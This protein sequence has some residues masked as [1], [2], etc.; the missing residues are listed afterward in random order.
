MNTLY[1][2]QLPEEWEHKARIFAALGDGT[3]QKILL[4]FEAGETI[5]L[6]TL[7]E[8]VALSR[9]A[10]V[11][12]VA[13]L[14]QAGLL[15]AR[16]QGREVGYVLHTAPLITCLEDVLDYAR[17]LGDIP[18]AQH[19]MAQDATQGTA[20]VKTAGATAS[21]PQGTTPPPTKGLKKSG[22]SGASRGTGISGSSAG[23]AAAH[24]SDTPPKAP[25]PLPP[26]PSPAL[27]PDPN[28]VP[29][30]A[31]PLGP[32]TAPADTLVDAPNDAPIDASAGTARTHSQRI[33]LFVPL[34]AQDLAY[35]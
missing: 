9:S 19:D 5:T 21:L 29:P 27:I 2:H 22:R 20:T 10:V 11:H 8:I 30:Q 14:E 35:D 26:V 31:P 15:V 12:H 34:S 25:L 32:L 17:K 3:R 33:S 1:L 13:V 6:K 4:L 16:R 23:I 28:P 7:V 24:L 18:C